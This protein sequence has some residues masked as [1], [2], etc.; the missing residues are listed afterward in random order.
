MFVS[1]IAFSQ[2]R[3]WQ[4]GEVEI[5]ESRVNREICD[6]KIELAQRMFFY[7]LFSCPPFF[8]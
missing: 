8:C 6:R 3:N 1:G 7:Y 4:G 2:K 5:E